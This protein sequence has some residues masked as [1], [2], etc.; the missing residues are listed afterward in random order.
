MREKILYRITSEDV[1]MVLDEDR[2]FSEQ[3]LDF[4]SEKIGEF[5]GDQWREAIEYALAGLDKK[6]KK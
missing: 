3:E 2:K 6:R 5:F 1:S 4:I